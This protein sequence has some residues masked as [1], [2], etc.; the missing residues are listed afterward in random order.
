MPLIAPNISTEFGSPTP[1]TIGFDD[2]YTG[3]KA[4]DAFRTEQRT[5]MFASV[6]PGP[7]SS[8]YRPPNLGPKLGPDTYHPHFP[9]EKKVPA[10]RDVGAAMARS[11]RDDVTIRTKWDKSL[12]T[13]EFRMAEV[14]THATHIH[15]LS[16]DR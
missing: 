11:Q 1:T 10:N 4:R 2:I 7:G 12:P 16:L 14:P 9:G 3:T 13:F 5:N 8:A 15:N 6:A